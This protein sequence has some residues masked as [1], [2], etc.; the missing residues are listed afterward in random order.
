M[1]ASCSAGQRGHRRCGAMGGC[2]VTSEDVCQWEV[3]SPPNEDVRDWRCD[4][5]MA[6]CDGTEASVLDMLESLDRSLL[7][8]GVPNRS[9][10]IEL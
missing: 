4:G 7:S 1:F 6:P 10:I 5:P 3:P 9:R 2:C 8:V